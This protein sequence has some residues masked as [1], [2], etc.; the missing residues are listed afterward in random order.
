MTN[1]QFY[2][3]VKEYFNT[4]GV[5]P[6]LETYRVIMSPPECTH[7]PGCVAVYGPN[8]NL[9]YSEDLYAYRFNSDPESVVSQITTA[10]DEH[11]RVRP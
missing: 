1:N 11:E 6:K 4:V 3:K 9:I 10:V 2:K 5:I 7:C 8:D